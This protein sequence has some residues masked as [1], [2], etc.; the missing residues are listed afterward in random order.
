M[1]IRNI[2]ANSAKDLIKNNQAI[3]IDVRE[4]V[5]NKEI[6]IKDAN[7]IPLGE[8]DINK[9]PKTD[10]KII[11]HCKAG[12]RS[13]SACKKLTEQNPNLD[14]YNLEGGIIAWK[15]S[16]CSVVNN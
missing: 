16:G 15:N 9:L 1:T 10:K 13:M 14:L 4:V 11:I 3:L 7:L 5:E 8:I 12:V 2:D 6:R